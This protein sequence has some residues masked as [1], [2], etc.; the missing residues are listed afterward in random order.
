MANLADLTSFEQAFIASF[1]GAYAARK[2][3]EVCAQ[4]NHGEWNYMPVEDAI[5]LALKVSD[6]LAEVN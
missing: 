5:H 1:L 2:Y 4:G 3:D 6:Q